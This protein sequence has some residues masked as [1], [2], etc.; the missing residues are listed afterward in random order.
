MLPPHSKIGSPEPLL[1]PAPHRR[2]QSNASANLVRR[3]AGPREARKIKL[4]VATEE[5]AEVF[6]RRSQARVWAFGVWGFGVAVGVG[7]GDW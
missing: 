3:R 6:L 1:R 5:L 4:M 2:K 7:L